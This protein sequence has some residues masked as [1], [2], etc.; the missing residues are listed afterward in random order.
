MRFRKRR[1]YYIAAFVIWLILL[2][3]LMLA[4]RNAE[5]SNI[6]SI[7]D[8]I[9]YFVITVS[10]VG[11][12]DFFPVT[13]VGRI[14]AFPFVLMSVG[15]LAFLISSILLLFRS[16]IFPEIVMRTT[17]DRHWYVFPVWNQQAQALAEKLKGVIVCG[18]ESAAEP[19]IQLE[20]PAQ[21]IVSRR[22]PEDCTILVMG[23]DSYQSYQKAL[24]LAGTGCRIV[25]ES[26]YSADASTERLILFDASDCG[27]RI[28][29]NENPLEKDGEEILLIGDGKNARALLTRAL[30]TNV[31]GPLARVTYHLFGEWD[32]YLDLHQGIG[33]VMDLQK[34]PCAAAPSSEKD[35]LIFHD[36]PWQ[37]QRSLLA[38]AD[39]IIVCGD[40][41]SENAETANLV[42]A[43]FP[44]GGRIDCLCGCDLPGVHS[45]MKMQDLYTPENVMQEHLSRNA[46]LMNDIYRASTGGTAPGWAELTAFLK[47]SNIASADH[48]AVKI[49]ILLGEEACPGTAPLTAALCRKAMTAYEARKEKDADL[50]RQIEHERWMRFYSMYNWAYGTKKDNKNRL[51]PDYR[52]YNELT[53]S[54]QAKDDYAWELIGAIADFLDQQAVN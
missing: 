18:T 6:H 38:S 34:G 42:T 2:A 16:L 13:L 44:A 4:E 51:H 7:G 9:W 47:Q 54:E 40:Q 52:P 36:G 53:L 20:L 45:F 37:A 5:G 22:K 27:A 35:R 24:Q 12:G 41:E 3:V 49:R 11:Y 39:R 14:A 46:I 33:H 50:F 32:S 25:C 15:L 30:L 17:M 26:S 48:L 31:Y 10:T 23:D 29:W 8:A 21:K 1:R 28:Y 43:W 19:F